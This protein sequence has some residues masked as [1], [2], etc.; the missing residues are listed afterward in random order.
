MKDILEKPDIHVKWL[1]VYR[2]PDNNRYF[3]KVFDS[4]TRILNAPPD[5]TILDAGCG[6]CDDSI[7]LAKRGFSV[8]AV[9]FSESA[10]QIAKM[11]VRS[12]G[13]EDKIKIQHEDVC[14][15]SFDDMVFDYIICWGVLM[16]I[17]DIG[18]AVSELSRVLKPGG[19][20]IVGEH[21]MYSLQLIITRAINK[22]FGKE[23]AQIKKTPAGLEVWRK[24]EEGIIMTRQGNI[25]WLI[26]EFR[27][28][29]VNIQKRISDQFTQAYTGD[30]SLRVKKLIHWINNLWFDYIKIP[31]FAV[32]NIL[33]LQKTKTPTYTSLPYEN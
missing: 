22:I 4:I 8:Q 15:L 3:D 27:N 2:T 17:P 29:G 20:I 14:S 25:K 30:Y 19:K 31:Y 1:D 11:K 5:S 24:E 9:D 10:L 32:D 33:I 21:N 18:N 13:L 26:N 16:T 6:D 7:R 23:Q 12:E 28:N